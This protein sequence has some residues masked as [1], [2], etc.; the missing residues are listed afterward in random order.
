[1]WRAFFTRRYEI[2]TNTRT[3]ADF[4][5]LRAYISDS[6]ASRPPIFDD[7]QFPL[8]DPNELYQAG[9]PK[10][11]DRLARAILAVSLR[12]GGL[13][14]ADGSS[15]SPQNLARRE[16]HHI[17]PVAHLERLG[18]GTG[19]VDVALNCALVTWRTNRNMSDKEPER[20]I[21]ERRSDEDPDDNRIR[22]RLTSHLVPYD[23]MV[24]G[25]YQEFL[26]QRAALVHDAMTRVCNS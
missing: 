18:F 5:A 8:P 16:Y 3:L 7:K 19:G 2:S 26:K 20:Y 14:L 9:W 21:A 22:E 6:S 1:L 12:N 17:F 23:E 25:E 4:Q 24:A 15:A 10:K 13:D 11:K